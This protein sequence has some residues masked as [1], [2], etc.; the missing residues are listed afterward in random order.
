[1]ILEIIL[2]ICWIISALVEGKRD[3]NFYHNKMTS[4]NPDKQNIHWLFTVERFI[5]WALI[6]KI[7]SLHESIL[8]TGIFSLSLVL[9][10]SF[11]HNGMYYKIRHKLDNNVYSK[12]WWSSSTT[13]EAFIELD[14]RARIFLVVVGFWGI[15]TAYII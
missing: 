12:G 3:A 15:V 11:F 13:S 7:Y 14:L 8:S 10:F 4:T 5:I 9:I 1:M 2:T 6:I